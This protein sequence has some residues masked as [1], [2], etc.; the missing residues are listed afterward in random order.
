[1][2]NGGVKCESQL[3]ICIIFRAFFNDLLRASDLAM[4]KP[5]PLDN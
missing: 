1:M 3:D 5:G 2:W 4:H